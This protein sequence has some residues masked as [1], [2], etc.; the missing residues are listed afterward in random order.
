VE[1][2]VTG[3]AAAT[4]GAIGAALSGA[5]LALRERLRRKR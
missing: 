4:V 2:A 1:D 3:F 5:G